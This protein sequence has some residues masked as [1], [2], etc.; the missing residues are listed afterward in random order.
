MSR[1]VTRRFMNLS[2]RSSPC[3]N[4][5]TRGFSEKKDTEVLDAS[6]EPSGIVLD[7]ATTKVEAHRR[8]MKSKASVVP[9]GF[10]NMITEGNDLHVPKNITEMAATFSGMPAEHANR[11]VTIAPR[12]HKTV[13]S[14]EKLSHIWMITWDDKE[15]WMNPLMGWTSSADPMSNVRLSFDSRE[16][17]IAFAERNGWKYR[18]RAATQLQPAEN[19]GQIKYAQVFLAN[20]I[21]EAMQETGGKIGKEIFAYPGYGQGNFFNP[22][23]YHGDGVVEQYGDKAPP[24]KDDAVKKEYTSFPKPFGGQ[25]WDPRA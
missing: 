21:T 6:K 24:S 9:T 25:R 11:T 2:R 18:L 4:T 3:L 10:A 13:Q 12:Q 16:E 20:K 22:L 7:P 19:Y 14:A 5:F 17:A 15:R 8:Y 1:L 23:K